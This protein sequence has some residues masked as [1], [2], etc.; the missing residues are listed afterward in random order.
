MSY[1][2]ESTFASVD[3]KLKFANICWFESVLSVPLAAIYDIRVPLAQS[4]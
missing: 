3:L 4:P 1:S 2:A